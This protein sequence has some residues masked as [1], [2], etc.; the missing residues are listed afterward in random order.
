M[1]V[2][3]PSAILGVRGTNSSPRSMTDHRAASHARSASRCSPRWPAGCARATVVLLPEKDGR[4]TA[5]TVTQ[6]DKKVVLDEPYAAVKQGAFGTTTAYK[7][8]A[9][10][11]EA[12]A[13][14]ALA[15][16][17]ARPASFTLYFVEGKDEFTDESKQVVET[18][19]PRSRTAAAPDVVVVG[20]T[21]LTG[22]DQIND[23]WDSCADFVKR[24]LVARGV[25]AD[26]VEA[27]SAACAIRSLRPGVS[28]GAQPRVE[29]VVR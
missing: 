11:V 4:Q 27:I 29:I 6:G 15:A 17:P 16:Q 21:D 10:E 7:S 3:T 20:H 24:Q 1:T 25:P 8:D 12:L 14:P 13:G 26:N 9:K 28:P 2:R 18:S 19:S 23:R 22:T 5:V